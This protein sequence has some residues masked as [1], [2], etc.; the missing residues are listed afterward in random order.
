MK[1]VVTKFVTIVVCDKTFQIVCFLITLSQGHID[2]R[3]VLNKGKFDFLT[4]YHYKMYWVTQ[5]G[6]S[7]LI[8]G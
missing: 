8:F 2:L 5:D 4:N 1:A 3:K 6:V 7:G